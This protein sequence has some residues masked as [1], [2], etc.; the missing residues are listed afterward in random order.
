MDV[1]QTLQ[2]LSYRV[3]STMSPNGFYIW[4]IYSRFWNVRP[5]Y[6]PG[7]C[8]YVTRIPEI[9]LLQFLFM[10]E[11]QAVKP[12][13]ENVAQSSISN[14]SKYS[15]YDLMIIAAATCF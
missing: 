6:T 12:T 2:G 10:R 3:C 14:G 7:G 9:R 15:E 8:C 13:K 1:A 4:I 5:S 11:T